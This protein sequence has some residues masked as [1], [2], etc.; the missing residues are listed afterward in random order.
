M[1]AVFVT[2]EVIPER[3]DEFLAGLE[4]NARATREEP[5]CLRFDILRGADDPHRFHF[6]ELYAS[7]SAFRDDHRHAA[8]YPAWREVSARCVV[9]GTHVNTYAEPVHPEQLPEFARLGQV[10]SD[11]GDATQPNSGVASPAHST[12]LPPPTEASHRG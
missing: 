7:E 12:R 3:V 6:Y 2:L 9:P 10:T 5:G 11:P 8:H 1:F 4:A